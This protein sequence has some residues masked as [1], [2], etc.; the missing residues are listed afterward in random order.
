MTVLSAL[1][2]SRHCDHAAAVPAARLFL[3]S[4][5]SVPRQ[6]GGLSSCMQILV[7]TVH[8]VQQTVEISQLQFLGWLSMRLLLCSDRCSGWVVQKTVEPPQWQF[9]VRPVL[10][11]GCCARWCNDLGLRNAWFDNGY[12]F[13]V[14]RM[15]FGSIYNFYVTGWTR[16]LR[17]ILAMLRLLVCCPWKSVHYFFE[18]PVFSAFSTVIFCAGRFFGALEHSQ[19]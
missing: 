6:S 5:S 14:S 4:F 17:S 2:W 13:C 8:T 15:A 11:Q 19:L 16:L 7:R 1:D 12:M 10:G 18:P 3:G 9:W